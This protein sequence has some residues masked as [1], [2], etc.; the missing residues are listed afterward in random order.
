MTMLDEQDMATLALTSRVVDS[1]VKP[2]SAREF[3]GLSQRI[4]PSALRGRTAGEIASEL[5]VPCED[6]ERIARLFDRATGLALAI[7]KLDHSGIWTITGLD[8]RYP[9][10]LRS[11]LGNVAPV[12]LHGVGD[13]SVLDTDGVGVVGS[14]DITAAGSQIA[15]EIAGAA[16]KSGQPLVS[17]AAR[18]V[19]QD[20]MNAALAVGGQVVGVLAD[21][22]E[23]AVNRPGTRRGVVD[24]QL[25]L[26]TPFSPAAPFSI[27]NAMGRNKIIYGLARCT[28][29]ITSDQEAGGT[30]AGAIEA[31]KNSY[32]H[33]ASWTGP[34]SGAGNG[35]LV[36]QG[37]VELSDLTRLDDLLH[38][39]VVFQQ[40]NAEPFD[41][42]L[43]LGF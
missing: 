33:V 40:I 10:R 17:G 26:V 42:Q 16:A 24:G 43:T 31:L 30:W 2:L 41:G 32:G 20:A 6:G 1:T 37:A 7:E 8:E 34:G 9:E 15:R 23:R 18:G 19:D 25:C 22:L 27:G 28:I 5:A 4:E 13:T 38:E 11:R 39:S 35:A 12:A 36:S 29:V 3:W 21:S 14:R